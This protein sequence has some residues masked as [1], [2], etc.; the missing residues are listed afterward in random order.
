MTRLNV[1]ENLAAQLFAAEAALDIALR[2]TATLAAMLPQARSDAYLSAVTGQKAFEGAAATLS[3]LT[4]ARGHIVDTH[5]RLAAIA[6]S[7]KLETLAVGPVDKPD[8][9][10]P[11]GGGTQGVLHSSQTR[12]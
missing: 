1:G 3:F 7:L 11:V 10:P 6:R 9:D 5:N 4:Q 2:E 12:P 8:D